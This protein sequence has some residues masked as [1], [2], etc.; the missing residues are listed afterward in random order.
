VQV[1]RDAAFSQLLADQQVAEPQWLWPTPEPG[2]YFVR[3]RSIDSRGQ[4]GPWGG[5][6]QLDVPRRWSWWWLAPLLLLGL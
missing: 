2:S 3:V 1:A 5:A 6:Q 4:A